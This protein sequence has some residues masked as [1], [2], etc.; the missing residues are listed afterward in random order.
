MIVP[1]KESIMLHF[2]RATG[3]FV[4]GYKRNTD[5][6]AYLFASITNAVH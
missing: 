1:E 5:V 2:G 4:G 6:G 3:P